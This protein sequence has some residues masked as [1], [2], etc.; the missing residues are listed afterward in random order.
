MLLT[1][2]ERVRCRNQLDALAERQR[3]MREAEERNRRIEQALGGPRIDTIDPS[4]RAYYD[5]VLA[6]RDSV[7]NGVGR[8]PGL[9]CNL[10]AL[11]GGGGG[12]PGDKIKVPGLPCVIVP[13]VGVLTEESRI[14]PP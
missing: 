12:A 9:A 14:S 2:E 6:A 4:K 10:G 5:A 8:P 1:P 13:P 7:R 3:A 11:F